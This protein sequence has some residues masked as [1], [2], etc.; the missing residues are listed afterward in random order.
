MPLANKPLLKEAYQRFCMQREP[1]A[2]FR[3][4]LDTLPD[5]PLLNA[6]KAF[7]AARSKRGY[8]RSIRGGDGEGDEE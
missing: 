5:D 1:P 7:F 4:W 6:W 3:A 2:E 8:A